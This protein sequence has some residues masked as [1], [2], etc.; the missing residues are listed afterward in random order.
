VLAP[1]G[2]AHVY[3]EGVERETVLAA[4]LRD[5][6]PV[7]SAGPGDQVE[8]VLPET[9]FYVEA[10]GQVSDTGL[11]VRYAPDAGRG[12]G[13]DRL[14]PAWEIRVDDVR[15]PVSGLIVHIGEV[16]AGAPAPGDR[17]WARVD[18]ERR[19][20]IMRNHTA[21]HLLDTLLRELLGR[22]VQQ[23]GSVVAPDRLRF[24]F[25]HS[26][27]LTQHELDAL[28]QAIND[29][30]LADHP[31][32]AA[33]TTYKKAVEEGAI[34]L[35]TE[36]YGDDVRVI[37]IGQ[38]EDEFS[39]ELCG[40][41]HVEHTGQIGLFHIVSEESVGAG[42]RRIEA[43]TGRAAYD[44]VRARLKTLEQVSAFLRVPPDQV[45]RVVRN[46]HSDLQA[47][48]K[49]VARLRAELALQHAD[50][51]VADARLVDGVA[52]VSAEVPDAELQ[53]LR[54]MSDRLRDQLGSAV[55]V[56]ATAVDGK[57]QIIAAVTDDLVQRGVHAGQLV[58]AIARTVG[59]GGGGKPSLAQAGGR[60]LD[61]LPEALAQ[62]PELVA[63]A[64][65]R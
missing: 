34:A 15:R 26:A 1:A 58:K 27:L 53:T 14:A 39:K 40:G 19:M 17:A 2:V 30:I 42:V 16:T 64:L 33:L 11:I 28:E 51:L 48:Q 13:Q 3:A 25:T 29:A 52:V 31:V 56:L 22:H 44:L 7:R 32:R 62:A 59:G 61:R 37:K 55:V 57:P 12:D 24:D 60:D 46:L 47:A 43:V 36:K 20:D 21:T 45:G 5:G 6:R 4:L 9:P 50:R 38:A 8:V 35:F 18:R 23:A 65:G 41:T 63:K 10:G 54:D 49:E